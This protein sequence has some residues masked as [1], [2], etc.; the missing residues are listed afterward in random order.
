MDDDAPIVNLGNYSY[1]VGV[2]AYAVKNVRVQNQDGNFALLEER[3]NFD[4][5]LIE[6]LFTL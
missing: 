5:T 6:S 4:L 1:S 3:L 2:G